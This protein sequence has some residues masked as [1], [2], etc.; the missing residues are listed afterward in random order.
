MSKR[1]D[2][3]KTEDN[4][5]TKA[6][7][8]AIA[9][10]KGGVGKTTTAF[11][12]GVALT[13]L[14]KKVLLVDM[15]PQADL[16]VSMGYINS[17]K[18][19]T[20]AHLMSR[21]LNDE[22]IN[23]T[24]AIVTHDEKI[25]LIPANLDLSAL[26]MSLVNAMNRESTLKNCLTSLKGNYDYIIIDSQPSLGMLAI[27]VL[28]TADKVI[29]PVQTQYLPAKNMGQLLNTISKV[30]RNINRNLK[31]D[32]ILLTLVDKRT[33]LSRDIITELESN[34]CGII[35]IFNTQIPNAVKVAEATS[36]GKSIFS[37]DKNS[38]VAE[39]YSQFAKEVD[40]NEREKNVSTISR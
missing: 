18:M 23:P 32:G 35:K 40:E 29:I 24:E 20:V 3:E 30:K 22:T 39:A 15:D 36:Q 38:K 9:N 27:N 17:D 37:Y 16:T 28:A 2:V 33:N 34:Y 4:V 1:D 21:A 19:I 25:D 11:N 14:G 26:E 13:K 8:I 31:V 5:K 12:L 6:K 10:Q 7:V